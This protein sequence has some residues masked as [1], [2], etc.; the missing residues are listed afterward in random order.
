M[1]I[2]NNALT[3]MASRACLIS[4]SRYSNKSSWFLAKPKG[5]NPTFPG[6][7]LDLSVFG[8]SKKGMEMDR[9]CLNCS[10]PNLKLSP[11]EEA[12]SEERTCRRSGAT[13]AAAAGKRIAIVPVKNFMANFF[14]ILQLERKVRSLERSRI[15]F[16]EPKQMD[17]VGGRRV[18]SL[19]LVVKMR[20]ARG[21]LACA[22]GAKKV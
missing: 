13:N 7:L 1:L 5:S 4:A 18:L 3:N 2:E 19:Y 20:Q 14:L 15:V 16:E 6:R 9:F 10:G 22:G 11:V 12:A 17:H 8:Q 21:G